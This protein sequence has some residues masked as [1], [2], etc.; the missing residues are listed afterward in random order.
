MHTNRLE[1]RYSNELHDYDVFPKVLPAGKTSRITIQ[2]RG[3]H[4]AFTQATYRLNVC[5]LDE[6]SPEQYPDRPNVFE[7]DVAPEE[8]GCI[9]F[10][11]EFFGEQQYFL[12]LSAGEFKLRLSVYSVFEDLVGRYPFRGDLHIHTFRSDGSQAPEIVAANYRKTGYD[13]MAITDHHR[14]Y[15]SLEAIE[16]YKDAPIGLTLVPGEEVHLPSDDEGGPCQHLN[17]VHIVNFGGAYSINALVRDDNIEQIV[18]EDDKRAVIP[19]P[20]PIRTPEEYWAEIDAYMP[21]IEIPASLKGSERYTYAA[22]HWIYKQIKQGGGL[23]IFCHPY[24]ITHGFHEPPSFVDAMME[25]HPFGAYEVLGGELYMEQNGFQAADYYRDVAKGR[26]YPIVGSTDSHNSVNSP[27]SHL[28]STIV[29]SPANER[30]ALIQSIEALY[31]TAVDTI[32]ENPRYVGDFRFVRY[33]T[34]LEKNYFPLHDELCFEEGR[35]MKDYVTGQPGA[36]ETLAVLS[37]RT[38]ALLKKYFAW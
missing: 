8:D 15:P 12:R 18:Y 16:A 23:G 17:S 32:D 27:G 11:F 1:L 14:Y 20:P 7:Y 22:C 3:R 36:K 34:F 37:G 13:F 30:A 28:C 35:A 24:W 26:I 33:A 4:A 10:S 9:R 5:P 25:G 21:T 38:Q 6:G 19:N 2:P 31:S 29:F